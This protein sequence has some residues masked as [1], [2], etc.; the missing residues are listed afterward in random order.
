M[1]VEESVM[2]DGAISNETVKILNWLSS[3]QGWSVNRSVHA[4]GASMDRL[5]LGS[6]RFVAM[7]KTT[8]T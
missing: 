4:G 8:F 6:K 3:V 5:L 1:P 7:S 2:K